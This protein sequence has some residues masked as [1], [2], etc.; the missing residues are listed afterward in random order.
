MELI[1][2][3]SMV[4]LW[5]SYAS[6]EDYLRNCMENGYTFGITKSCPKVL[7]NER[8]TNYQFLQVYDLDDAQV[9]QLIQPTMQEIH[10]ILALDWRKAAL[11]LKGVGLNEE[12]IDFIESDFAKAIMV[13]PRMMDDPFVTKKIYGM[14]KKRII[15]A[16]IGVI[17]VRGN[18]S[19][20]SGDPYALCQSIFGLEVT[21]LLKAGEIYNK[22]WLDHGVDNVVCFR[23]PMTC[24]NNVIKM[25]V[26]G[27]EEAQHWYRY[28][29]SCSL[30]N[31]WTPRRLR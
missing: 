20:I 24:A 26:N 19:I 18:Y 7:E 30:L 27:S 9:E 2:T 11:F 21:G 29:V 17:K 10:D 16:K 31:A 4:K 13:E 15:D 25:H 8:S 22:Y 28:M 14:I 5:D 3:T 1:L 12:N 6:C 23:A